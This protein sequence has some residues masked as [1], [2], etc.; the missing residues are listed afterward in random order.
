MLRS[1]MTFFLVSFESLPLLTFWSS[2]K[3]LPSHFS[4]NFKSLSHPFSDPCLKLPTLYLLVYSY[5]SVWGHQRY[6][7]F[8]II[9]LF[10]TIYMYIYIGFTN[11]FICISSSV[12][13]SPKFV[14]AFLNSDAL[15]INGP[16]AILIKHLEYFYGFF[17]LSESFIF[18]AIIAW[19]KPNV[20]LPSLNIYFINHILEFRFHWILSQLMT[21]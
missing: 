21:S 11:H 16:I 19:I 7:L 12:N 6:E 9:Y 5:A 20:P 14:I 17:L 15:Y 8:M 4:A 18:L 1:Q 2:P 3:S 10:I 13:Y